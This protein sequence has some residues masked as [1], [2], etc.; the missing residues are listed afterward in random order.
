MEA[1]QKTNKN[2]TYNFYTGLLQNMEEVWFCIKNNELITVCILKLVRLVKNVLTDCFVNLSSHMCLIISSGHS[3][4]NLV[5]GWRAYPLF[6]ISLLSISLPPFGYKVL[7]SPITKLSSILLKVK[8][9]LELFKNI[10][11]NINENCLETW[12]Q[13]F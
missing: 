10:N 8:Y 11:S 9:F 5:H 3:N 7:C 6:P 1:K 2:N 13:V 4:G 12:L